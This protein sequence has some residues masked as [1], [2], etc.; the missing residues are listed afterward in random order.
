MSERILSGSSLLSRYKAWLGSGENYALAKQAEDMLRMATL[1]LGA[2]ERSDA[3][4]SSR[5]QRDAFALVNTLGMVNDQ[6]YASTRNTSPVV[7]ERT[8]WALTAIGNL[9]VI[10]EILSSRS[11][12]RFR[13]MEYDIG[14]RNCACNA[15]IAYSQ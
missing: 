10:G 8:R 14:C 4:A 1:L 12:R 5:V 13:T 3:D 15:T 2:R 9:A 7:A 11:G 6:V